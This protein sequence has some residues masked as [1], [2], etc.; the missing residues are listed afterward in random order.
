MAQFES[1][2]VQIIQK[3]SSGE[4]KK[5]GEVESKEEQ[6]SG[7]DKV[8]FKMEA[9]TVEVEA[10]ISLAEAVSEGPGCDTSTPLPNK[11][12]E[13]SEYDGEEES[14]EDL[15]EEP[16]EEDP[17]S[18]SDSGTLM[19]KDGESVDEDET[20]EEEDGSGEEDVDDSCKE[21]GKPEE[22]SSSNIG[23]LLLE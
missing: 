6:D 13:E 19:E 14:E 2:G 20:T 8:K 4:N 9:S 21:Q 5:E 16:K 12:E 22:V 7:V 11:V 23:W 18:N 15:E 17:F 1:P 3:L 10:A